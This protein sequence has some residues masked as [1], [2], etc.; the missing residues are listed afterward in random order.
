[1]RNH[2][3][4]DGN[5]RT[6]FAAMAMFLELNCW[7]MACGEAEVTAMV[8]QAAAGEISEHDWNDWVVRRSAK[9]S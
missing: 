3:F 9:K 5:K 1:L 8:L 2:P 4:L 6:A 7:D